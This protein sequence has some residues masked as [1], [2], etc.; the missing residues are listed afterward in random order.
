MGA[1]LG[2]TRRPV[3]LHLSSPHALCY[4]SFYVL[5][6]KWNNDREAHK[7]VS[8]DG[9]YRFH[10]ASEKHFFISPLL[11]AEYSHVVVLPFSLIETMR[12][13]T[14]RQGLFPRPSDFLHSLL[15]VGPGSVVPWLLGWQA[16]HIS[17]LNA[18]VPQ[19]VATFQICHI[20]ILKKKKKT[21]QSK[22]VPYSIT[23]ITP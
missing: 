17:N 13:K 23:I 19:R 1:A 16:N 18:W 15:P 14:R 12:H 21:Q 4:F 10:F 3:C 9:F 6:W 7:N 11:S 8:D 5:E 20:W 2:L 22:T